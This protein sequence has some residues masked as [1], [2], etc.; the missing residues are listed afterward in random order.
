LTS[1]LDGNR[2]PALVSWREQDAP[3]ADSVQ[4]AMLAE[5]LAEEGSDKALPLIESLAAS[6]PVEAG[7]ILARLR[8]RQ[9]K[10]DDAAAALDQA[11]LRY[12]TEP[13][14]LQMLVE[15]SL[16]LAVEIGKRDPALGRR[17]HQ[18]LAEP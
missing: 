8:F 10:I 6:Q 1:W 17:L 5:L 9:I 2:G 15:R 4:T 13:W 7:V 16:S 14:A 18:T 12:R 3:P 11:L